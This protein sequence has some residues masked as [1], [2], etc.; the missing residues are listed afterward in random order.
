[1]LIIAKLLPFSF[2]LG[3]EEKEGRCTY[4]VC[5]L[6]GNFGPALISHE[7]MIPTEIR[8]GMCFFFCGNGRLYLYLLVCILSE[9]GGEGMERMMLFL[10][11]LHIAC[12]RGGHTTK[13]AR[14]YLHNQALYEHNY[15]RASISLPRHHGLI[16][17]HSF[18]YGG[19]MPS[20]PSLPSICRSV[21]LS[22]FLRHP[23]ENTFR[24]IT[25][26]RSFISLLSAVNTPSG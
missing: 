12:L 1:M 14:Y 20:P 19:R 8:G 16:G 25:R 23:E 26:V 11:L 22:S 9:R 5:N 24:R 4:C 7:I 3:G 17:F 10:S 18:R 21:P 13:Q 2:F 6:G 15:R